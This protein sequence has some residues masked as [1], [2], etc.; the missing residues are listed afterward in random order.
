V[1]CFCAF[2]QDLTGL[3]GRGAAILKGVFGLEF[4]GRAEE[5]STWH[6]GFWVD[7]IGMLI[8]DGKD[9]VY[10]GGIPGCGVYD[11]EHI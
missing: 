10:H 2:D 6:W 3:G 4:Y 7:D 11:L 8:S 1:Q 5:C 9:D